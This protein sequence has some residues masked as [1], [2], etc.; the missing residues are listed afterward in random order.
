[1]AGKTQR[2]TKQGLEVAGCNY[3]AQDQIWRDH[4]D[5]AH[6]V[7]T[8]WPDR[9]G[10][11]TLDYDELVKDEFPNREPDKTK[12]GAAKKALRNLKEARPATPIEK[13]ITVLPSTKPVPKTTAGEVGWRSADKLLALDKYGTYARPNGNILKQL[14]WPRD[15]V[16]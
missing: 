3:V 16:E 11:L 1:M 15:A 5:N 9:W 6:A 13:Y 10:F 12:R 7:A 2:A 4:V 14:N 8:Q